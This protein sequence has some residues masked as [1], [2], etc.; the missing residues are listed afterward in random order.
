MLKSL[1]LFDQEDSHTHYR[2]DEFVCGNQIL[3]CPINEPNSKGRRM[4]IPRGEWF[5]FWNKEVISGGKEIWVD[6]ELDSMPIF[7]KAGAVIPK[8][9]VQQYVGEKDIDQ[10]TLDVYYKK[11][12]EDSELYED[13]DDG[14]DY[15][16]GR[17]SLKKF[18]VQG[19][20]NK[21][22]VRIHKRGEYITSYD[23]FKIN[24]YGLPF[25]VASIKVDNEFVDLKELKFENNSLVVTKEFTNLQIIGA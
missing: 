2:T 12:K 23:T 13:A 15:T 14:Y 7:V 8:Y 20:D 21:L 18:N 17:Y 24:V 19:K 5:N 4:Y 6:A 16:K 11:G 3:I 1:V 22:I 10:L 25:E 9:P